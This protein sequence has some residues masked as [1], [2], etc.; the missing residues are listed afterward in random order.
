MGLWS[1]EEGESE[2]FWFL[3]GKCRGMSFIDKM[4]C[5]VVELFPHRQRLFIYLLF[6]V[7]RKSKHPNSIVAISHAY[8]P[9]AHGSS[10]LQVGP[11]TAIEEMANDSQDSSPRYLSTSSVDQTNQPKFK[12]I[13]RIY[14]SRAHR[15]HIRA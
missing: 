2:D 8:S 12:T 7:P 6:C 9:C 3:D 5:F 14:F 10:R 4:Y 11:Q 1:L 13:F 15:T